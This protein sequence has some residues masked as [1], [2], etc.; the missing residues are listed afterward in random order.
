MFCPYTRFIVGDG[1]RVSFWHDTWCGDPP[2]KSQC[3]VMFQLAWVKEA[4]VCDYMEG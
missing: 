4:M 1:L 3:P 2:L